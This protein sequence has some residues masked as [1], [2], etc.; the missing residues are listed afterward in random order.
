LGKGECD[1]R[2]RLGERFAIYFQCF[3]IRALI[4]G[5]CSR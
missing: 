5:V 3:A 2:L 4:A 1:P